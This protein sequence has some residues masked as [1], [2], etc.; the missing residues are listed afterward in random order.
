MKTP[1]ASELEAFA[2]LA[3]EHLDALR[4]LLG[5]SAPPDMGAVQRVTQA[6][7]A[8]RGS[9]SLIGLDTFQSFLGKL[10]GLLEEV[11]SSEVPW[12]ARLETLLGEAAH[13]Q[14]R[15]LESLRRAE[16]SA[17]DEAL[18]HVE[19]LVNFWRREEARR[20]ENVAP[21]R[22]SQLEVARGDGDGDVEQTLLSLVES[23]RELQAAVGMGKGNAALHAG[24]KS[25]AS[26]LAAL[27]ETLEATSREVPTTTEKFDEGFRNHC[28]GALRSLVESAA[29]EVLD[30]AEDSDVRLALRATGAI[31]DID[32]E[33]GGVLLEILRNLWSDSLAMQAPRGTA[34]IDCVIREDDERLIAEV[35]DPGPRVRGTQEHDVF[36]RYTGLRRCRPDVES[37]QGLVWVEPPASPG[38]RFRVALPRTTTQPSAQIVRIGAH[39]IAL[40]TSAI[41]SM[42]PLAD[43]QATQDQAGAVIEVDGVRYPVLHL[44]FVLQDVSYDELERETVVVVGSF[45]RRAALFASGPSGSVSGPRTSAPA[46]PWAGSLDTVRGAVPVLDIGSLLGSRRPG[47]AAP[48]EPPDDTSKQAASILVVN[49]SEVERGTLAG[50]LGDASYRTLAV[51]SAEDALEALQHGAADL[52]LCDLRLPEMNAQRLAE[53]R[54]R[55]DRLA[56]VPIL[57]VLSHAGEQSHLVVQQLGASGFVRSPIERDELLNVVNRLVGGSRS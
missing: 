4:E 22:E 6:T 23:A 44:A 56:E 16:T 12:S 37:L 24:L 55:S 48:S 15:F 9:A 14:T 19:E 54:K 31:G 2:T 40:P 46:G 30:R 47:S 20:Y 33:L 42:H 11:H 57:L 38:C 1:H 8:L 26:E 5:R 36:S 45:E 17:S 29:R 34:R 13:A 41:E 7:R 52:L 10:F 35:H 51:Q 3:H 25:L 18:V 21:H 27:G 39:E 32:D 49:S 53:L 28:E 50:L 43:V